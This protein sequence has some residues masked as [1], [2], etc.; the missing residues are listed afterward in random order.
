MSPFFMSAVNFSL[1]RHHM[2][3]SHHASDAVRLHFDCLLAHRHYFSFD[4]IAAVSVV[5]LINF[6]LESVIQ[7][8][9]S[10]VSSLVNKI[11]CRWTY[12]AQSR[13]SLSTINLSALFILILLFDQ[14]VD[15]IVIEDRDCYAPAA[16][17]LSQV[18][19]PPS[20]HYASALCHVPSFR[21]IVP[22][23][24]ISIKKLVAVSHPLIFR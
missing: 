10:L 24:Y 15:V 13:F 4:F 17:I 23:E 9:S 8:T 22:C 6:S 11:S 3:K 7:S 2:I 21:W 14:Q 18:A 1:P 12:F 20:H 5:E 19:F 16:I